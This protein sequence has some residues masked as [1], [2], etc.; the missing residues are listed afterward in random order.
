MT[1]EMLWS[2]TL[3]IV[4]LS[5]MLIA[6]LFRGFNRAD[7]ELRLETQQHAYHCGME[8]IPDDG[9]LHELNAHVRID[10][11]VYTWEFMTVNQEPWSPNP[12]PVEDDHRLTHF[13]GLLAKYR[14]SIICRAPYEYEQADWLNVVAAYAALLPDRERPCLATIAFGE[15]NRDPHDGPRLLSW[16]GMPP[17][18]YHLQLMT[19]DNNPEV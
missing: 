1:Y 5:I 13:K 4:G 12:L 11:G 2:L 3:I 15:E 6:A 19:A 18:V 14:A 8:N 7:Y 10:N 16:N 9:E 17:G